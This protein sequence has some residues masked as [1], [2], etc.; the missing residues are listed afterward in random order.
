MSSDA[1]KNSGD[2]IRC[3]GNPRALKGLVLLMLLYPII[4]TI[5]SVSNGR[6]FKVFWLPALVLFLIWL[7]WYTS[8][9]G[10]YVAVN[11]RRETLYASN[12]FVKMREIPIAAI[13]RIGTRGMFVGEATIV[14]ITYIKPIGK[15]QTLGYSTTNY[16]D[17]A[18]LK[19]ILE[20]L[21][22]INPKL[23]IPPEL[24]KLTPALDQR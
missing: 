15:K 14:E 13:T 1:A 21:V 24:R 2:E 3:H 7:F 11:T 17:H 6:F 8:R 5:V 16:L 10:T 20:A 19:K 12:F 4:L 22:S 23:T 18:N 9:W